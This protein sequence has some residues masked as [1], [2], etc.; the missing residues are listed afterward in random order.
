MNKTKDVTYLNN[1]YVQNKQS[2]DLASANILSDERALLKNI[3]GQYGEEFYRQKV[4]IPKRLDQAIANI[5][6]DD[7]QELTQLCQDLKVTSCQK[8]NFSD[9]KQATTTL[10]LMLEKIYPGQ[11]ANIPEMALQYSDQILKNTQKDR[12]ASWLD[13]AFANFGT[14]Q[15]SNYGLALALS[16]SNSAVSKSF[17]AT[18]DNQTA[19]MQEY[20]TAVAAS[21]IFNASQAFSYANANRSNVGDYTWGLSY[22]NAL[23]ND[24]LF[25]REFAIGEMGLSSGQAINLTFNQL[26]TQLANVDVAQNIA[27][28]YASSKYYNYTGPADTSIANVALLGAI[29]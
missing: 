8:E 9:S 10:A 20:Q 2:S 5:S 29:N 14:A 4:E 23:M 7:G 27:T 11:N 1:Y 12:T 18:V 24:D 3:Y 22:G 6:K 19:K 17:N 26:S 15:A 16:G 25:N 28:N 13:S 21:Q